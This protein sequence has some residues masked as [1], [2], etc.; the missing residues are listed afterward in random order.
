MIVTVS[1]ARG[2]QRVVLTLELSTGTVPYKAGGAEAV[3]GAKSR[4]L[5]VCLCRAPQSTKYRQLLEGLKANSSN[6]YSAQEHAWV[7]T[8]C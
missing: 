6:L 1:K 5:R 7:R 4:I 3:G 2:A 8:L